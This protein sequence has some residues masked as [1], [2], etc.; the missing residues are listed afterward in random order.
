MC[1]T[2]LVPSLL[3]TYLLLNSCDG[4]NAFWRHSV[5]VS[6][7]SRKHRTLSVQICVCQ[8]VRLT[9][10][11]VDWCRNVCTLYKQLSAIPATWSSASL[12][13]GQV[14]HKTSST[15]QLVSG[16][17]DYVQAWGKRTSLSAELK[18]ALFRANTLH[19]RLV[20]EPPTVYRGKRVILRHFH[21][22]YLEVKVKWSGVKVKWRY[23][24]S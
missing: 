19:N 4:N 11:F 14:Y 5:L 3:L 17:S 21:R 18:P 12:T 6:C 24:E 2:L 15:K 10:E 16:E 23:K 8:T 1:S 9:T 7:F 20:S 13:H 22:S